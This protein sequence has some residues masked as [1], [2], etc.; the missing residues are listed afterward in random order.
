VWKNRNCEKPIPRFFAKNRTGNG[1][2]GT[3]TALLYRQNSWNIC[4]LFSYY[5]VTPTSPFILEVKGQGHMVGMGKHLFRVPSSLWLLFKLSAKTV[6]FVCVDSGCWQSFNKCIEHCGWR[7]RRQD[8]FDIGWSSCHCKT[9]YHHLCSLYSLTG[10]FCHQYHIL[11]WFHV[12]HQRN[13]WRLLKCYLCLPYIYVHQFGGHGHSCVPVLCQVL[14]EIISSIHL[15]YECLT[16]P[17]KRTLEEI[18]RN[19]SLVRIFL[20]CLF[21]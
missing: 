21:C 14:D 11:C 8:L 7:K 5:M 16:L 20:F 10:L 9:S 6:L 19:P 12:G 4:L 1:N 3:V 2:N 15:G 17:R 13:I 18:V